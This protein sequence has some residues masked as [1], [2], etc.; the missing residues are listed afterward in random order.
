MEFGWSGR[1]RVAGR[2]GR[3]QGTDRASAGLERAGEACFPGCVPVFSQSVRG[4]DAITSW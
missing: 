4:P 1:G 2:D 3:N